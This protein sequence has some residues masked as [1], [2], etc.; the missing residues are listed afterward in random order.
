[1]GHGVGQQYDPVLLYLDHAAG[2]IKAY[3]GPLF[4]SNDNR[5]CVECGDY[6]SVILQYLERTF[7]SGH[8]DRP[9]IA[10]V[11]AFVRCDNLYLHVGSLLT[12]PALCNQFLTL[13]YGV[14]NG[15]HQHE[16]SLRVLVNGAVDDHIEAPDRIFNGYQLAGYV[17]K[18]L[19]NVEGL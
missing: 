15:S 16:G 1:M 2:N 17:C 3:L 6:G 7:P 11:N 10:G 19:G 5:A 13:G 18:L 12:L 9:Y 14:L 8:T 4:I